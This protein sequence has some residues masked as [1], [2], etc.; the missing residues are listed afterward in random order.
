MRVLFVSPHFPDDFSKQTYGVFKRLDLFVSAI[1]S[2][3]SSLDMLFYTPTDYEISDEK[4]LLLQEA[5]SARWGIE[6]KL[7]LCAVNS[8]T[9]TPSAI[10]YYIRPIF[11]VRWQRSYSLASGDAQIRAFEMLLKRK[12]DY[13]FIHRLYGMM[14]VL[15]TRRPTAPVFLDLD[16]I[17]HRWFYDSISR[18]PLWPAKKLLYFQIPALYLMEKAAVKRAR[19]TFLCSKADRDYIAARWHSSNIAQIQNA[20]PVPPMEPLTIAKTLLFI[21]SFGYRPNVLAAS[22]LIEQI[23]P[24]ILA[25]VP[26]AKLIIAG[27]HP[28]NIPAYKSPPANV[29]FTGFATDI[30][31]LYRGIRCVVC[32]IRSGGGTRLKVIEGALRGKAIV[33]TTIGA[34]GLDLQD[35]IH[36]LVRDEKADFVTACVSLLNDHH[37]ASR[38]GLNARTRGIDLYDKEKIA[39]DICRQI[40]SDLQGNAELASSVS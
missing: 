33:C 34:K 13:I 8:A 20:L 10:G 15:L 11:D 1:S 5:Y 14:P 17:E 23:W 35:G 30:D 29:V 24:D 18:P 31:E 9:Q 2:M 12:H 38:L 32:P 40:T 3:C 22:E 26:D 6:I 27:E 39:Q 25:Q 4:T 21:G 19:R 36:L 16:E 37:E 7:Y 28:N